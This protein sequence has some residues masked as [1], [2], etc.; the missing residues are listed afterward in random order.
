MA[1]IELRWMAAI[2]V[3]TRPTASPTMTPR[4]A[5]PSARPSTS[6]AGL[7]GGVSRSTILP[8]ILPIT[9]EDE[10]F[11]KAFCVIAIMMRPGTR[12]ST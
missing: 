7:S 12:N 11:A 9:S 1:A 4:V 5:P 6:S 8:C 3:S 10:V 2:G